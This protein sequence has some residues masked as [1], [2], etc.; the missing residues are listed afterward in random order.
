MR[1]VVAGAVIGVVFGVVLSWSGMTSPEVIREALLFQASYLYLFMASAVGTAA[2]GL[3]L[4]RRHERRALLADTPLTWPRERIDRRHIVGSIVFG[5]GWGLSDACPGP[6]ATQVG[7]GIAWGI[8]TLAGVVI[9]V[10][11]FLR[12]SDR[13]TEPSAQPVP[14][15]SGAHA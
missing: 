5:I 11:A 4:L 6:I 3:W 10:Y 8:V 12:S 9:G 7:Q 13:E 1:R 14:I 15:Q 2:A